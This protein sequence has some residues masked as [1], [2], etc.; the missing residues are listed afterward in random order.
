MPEEI[1]AEVSIQQTME[2]EEATKYINTVFFE[3]RDLALEWL[4]K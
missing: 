1:F 2:E 4:L 3:N